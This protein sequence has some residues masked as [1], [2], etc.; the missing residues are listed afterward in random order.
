MTD[1]LDALFGP[2]GMFEI[3]TEPVR[4]RELP[5]FAQRARSITNLF[6][7]AAAHG[8]NEFLVFGDGRRY[9]YADFRAASLSTASALRTDYDVAQGDR[10]GICAANSP[11]WIFAFFGASLLGAI[12]VAYNGWW[13]AAEAQHA[14]ALTEPKVVIFDRKRHERIVGSASRSDAASTP[15]TII[16]ESDFDAMLRHEAPAE[17]PTI[18]EDDVALILF[19]SGTTGHPKGATVPHRTVV[20]FIQTLWAHGAKAMMQAGATSAPTPTVP[21]VVM[22]LFHLSG[23]YSQ[24]LMT[25]MTGQKSV[26][27]TGRFDPKQAMELSVAE[28]VNQWAGA[29]THLYRIFDHPD[30]ESFD[31]TQIQRVS[32][33]GSATTTEMIRTQDEKLPHLTGSTSS[34]YGSTESGA[35]ISLASHSMLTAN[36]ACVGT[37]LPTVAVKIT[38]DDG[39][40][41]PVGTDGNICV[42]SAYTISGYWNDPEATDALFVDDG[43]V[44]TGDYG[45]LDDAGLLYLASRTR[46]LIIRGGE[47]IHPGEIEDRLELH[48]A[49]AEV[50]LVGID[51]RELGQRSRAIVVLHAD[52]SVDAAELQSFVGEALASYKIPDLVEF[53]ELAL[54][55]NAT[56]KVIKT[57]L[58]AG[59]EP[60]QMDDVE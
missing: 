35:V 7:Q 43:W 6:D 23:L 55:R 2:G 39:D 56:G 31:E 46:E 51:D 38:N 32:V 17:L 18:D 24:L 8:D 29:G 57:A 25:M 60:E 50:A 26:W 59:V 48:P 10:V 27:T 12:P 1:A 5:V 9:S 3:T 58:V 44:L 37:L 53:R 54:P 42:R 30:F 34:G 45:H 40:E 52:E 13:T 47:N 19:T 49:V 33:G 14:D 16:I 15:G 28:G 21:L 11:E 20:G 4:G 41:L 36:P 22:P